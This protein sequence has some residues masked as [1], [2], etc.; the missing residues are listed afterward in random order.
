MAAFG[1]KSELPIITK[2]N[3]LAFNSPHN[4]PMWRKSLHDELGLFDTGYRSA[5]DY[6][7]WV[8]CLSNH[9]T[10]GKIN[11]PHVVYYQNPEG[12]STRPD[13]QG[14]AEFYRIL[15]LYSEKLTSSI[16]LQSNS[17][18]RASFGI[19]DTSALD[20]AFRPHYDLLQD[21]LRRCGSR[22]FEEVAEKSVGHGS[23]SARQERLATKLLI[24][25]VFFQLAK[26]GIARVWVSL[27]SRLAGMPDLEIFLLDR[28]NCPEIEGVKRVPFPSW[29]MSYTVADSLLIQKTCDDLGIEVFTSTYYT[30]AVTTP[31]VQMVYDM[32]PEVMEFDLSA[33]A[34]KE[35]QLTLSYATFFA[36]ISANTRHDLLHFYPE[37]PPSRAVV[38]H[39]GVDRKIFNANACA[40]L[41]TFKAAYGIS[42][43][44]FLFV[45]SREQNKGYK[46]ASLFFD[47][48][49]I[50]KTARY[51]VVCVG[52]ETAVNPRWARDLPRGI[53]IIRLDLS[54][55]ELA[56]AYSGAIALV[57]P[58]LYEG[59]GMPVVEA[60]ASGC[61]VITTQHGSLSEVGGEATLAISGRD[62][63]ELLR[64]LERVQ[65]PKTRRDLVAAGFAQAAK[66][67][68]DK[69]ASQFHD[70]LRRAH[71]ERLDE[72]LTEFRRRWKKLRTGQAEVD[73]GFD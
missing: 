29:T 32:I 63:Y 4:A 10:F 16:L 62:R 9:K 43:T 11:A 50:D 18:L 65:F 24:D 72:P 48:I 73:V 54:D 39:C 34:W 47:A 23:G 49:R 1:F 37:I 7:F 42:D 64:A 70:L 51:D 5:G 55:T 45:G 17:D 38:A 71:A 2:H 41:A 8:R 30:S 52:G 14:L 66:F 20:E 36:C 13:T 69:A 3:L 46:N 56:A 40:G 26:T 53:R 31:Q 33:R 61:P 21:E 28:G 6:E 12:I 57:Y 60:M 25:G 59:F 22:R 58:S 68:W 67:D 15:S 35:K 44:Y 19:E 27:L